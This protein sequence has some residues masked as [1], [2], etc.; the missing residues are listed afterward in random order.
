ML[1]FLTQYPQAHLLLKSDSFRPK[2]TEINVTL[3]ECCKRSKLM[4]ILV[5][6][7][8]TCLCYFKYRSYNSALYFHHFTFALT[9][10]N[11]ASI[12]QV[13][14]TVL[15]PTRRKQQY[16]FPD[17]RTS[18]KCSIFNFFYISSITINL[19]KC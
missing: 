5:F 3:L 4:L 7:L 9:S 11:T 19:S 6:H 16:V 2:L 8:T 17:D 18:G 14:L 1:N 10:S 15:Y 13:Q 12:H